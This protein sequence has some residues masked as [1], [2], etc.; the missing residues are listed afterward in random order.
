MKKSRDIALIVMFA[1][2]TFVFQV[3]IG[4]VP[5]LITGVS[6]IGYAFTIVYSIIQS[7]A[8]LM[9][10]GRR[11]RIFAQ[12]LLFSLL[13][14]PLIPTFTP[15]AAMAAIVNSLLV[16]IIFNSFYERFKKANRV[17][18]WI[19]LNQVYYWA[20]LPLWLLPFLALF[21]PI[22]EV[23]ELWF[24]P[25][26]SVM[27]PIMIVGAIAGSYIGYKIYKRVENIATTTPSAPQANV[28]I[29]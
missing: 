12:G 11:W 6:G 28:Q 10:E 21:L 14:V 26:M 9:Y 7:V 4:Q 22:Q 5:N 20:T 25:L 23:I 24:I 18:W 8:F 16:D 17:F 2:L 15:P 3:L 13:A 29:S 27:I 1:V 19:L